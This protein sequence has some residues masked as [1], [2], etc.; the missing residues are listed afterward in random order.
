MTD[1]QK[2]INALQ[3]INRFKHESVGFGFFIYDEEGFILD[4]DDLRKIDP[5]ALKI[6]EDSD[7]V[8]D[9]SVIQPRG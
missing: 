1:A 9:G 7:W 3:V 4:K 5:E 2:W 8:W 6:L